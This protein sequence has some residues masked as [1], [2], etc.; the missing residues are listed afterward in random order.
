[1]PLRSALSCKRSTIA[2]KAQGH[3]QY[4]FTVITVVFDIYIDTRGPNR[5]STSS[6]MSPRCRADL[7]SLVYR[8]HFICSQSGLSEKYPKGNQ[9][10]A[11]PCDHK[12]ERSRNIAVICDPAR[13]YCEQTSL[14]R[15]SDDISRLDRCL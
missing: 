9:T 8:D 5:F 12:V 15:Q 13:V 14:D 7:S 6:Q 10:R 3:N 4:M 1:M 11:S 2:V